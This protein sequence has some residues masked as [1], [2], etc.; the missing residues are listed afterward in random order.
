MSLSNYALE[1]LGGSHS[2]AAAGQRGRQPLTCWEA[3]GDAMSD[4]LREPVDGRVYSLI[5]FGME[6]LKRVAVTLP[7]IPFALRYTRSP[8]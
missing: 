7:R 2:L 5:A 1:Q 3:S 6:M 4:T 8:S